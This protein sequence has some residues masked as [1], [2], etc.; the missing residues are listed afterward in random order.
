MYYINLLYFHLFTV[1]L[2]ILYTKW[3]TVTQ[4]AYILCVH[5]LSRRSIVAHN[6]CLTV[7]S[8]SVVTTANTNPTTASIMVIRKIIQCSIVD[9]LRGVVVALTWLAVKAI[10][11]IATS[12]RLVVIQRLTLATL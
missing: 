3:E 8:L 11:L 7:T 9:T 10:S 12:E 5:T 6:A 2:H 1:H 4:T